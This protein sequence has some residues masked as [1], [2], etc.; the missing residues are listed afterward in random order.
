MTVIIHTVI[1]S[2]HA[3]ACSMWEIVCSEAN[4]GLLTIG[5]FYQKEI[6]DFNH[7]EVVRVQHNPKYD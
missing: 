4:T 1:E 5:P 7:F 2:P 3:L 6:T